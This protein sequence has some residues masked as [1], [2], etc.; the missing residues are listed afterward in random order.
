MCGGNILGNCIPHNYSVP[1]MLAWSIF[2]K[3]KSQY[4]K[5]VLDI[6]STEDFFIDIL[7]VGVYKQ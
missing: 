4:S 6:G 1:I 7:P 3:I 2:H 5:V